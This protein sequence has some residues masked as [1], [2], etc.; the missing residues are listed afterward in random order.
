MEGI[1]MP[2]SPIVNGGGGVQMYFN[3]DFGNQLFHYVVAKIIAEKRGLEFIPPDDFYQF[4]VEGCPSMVWTK[5]PLIKMQRT[6]GS[7]FKLPYFGFGC[8][9]WYD[10]DKLPTDQMLH[11]GY[12]HFCNYS[13]LKPYKDRI[14]NDWLKLPE[15]RFVKTSLDTLYVHV[16]RHSEYDYVETLDV[17]NLDGSQPCS[18]VGLV[19][20]IDRMR[21]AYQ[22]DRLVLLSNLPDHPTVM[23]LK[24]YG[25]GL[26]LAVEIS[27][28]PWDLDFMMLASA[29]LLITTQSTYGWWAAFLGKAVKVI[30]PLDKGT[31]W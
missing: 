6:E 21:Q 19:A 17:I 28:Q 7:R 20:A 25:K 9:Y 10:L 29:K 12:G 3:G 15:E 5:E 8:R 31:N 16:R 2:S 22:I 26:G 18:Y 27:W 4:G 1:T 30:M 14:K 23:K 11:C 24:D 13:I